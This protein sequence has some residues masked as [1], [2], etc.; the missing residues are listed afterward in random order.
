MAIL[1]HI[2]CPQKQHLSKNINLSFLF[3]NHLKVT[4]VKV[5][6]Y[7]IFKEDFVKIL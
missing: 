5:D 6:H 1:L 3:Q 7:T 2:N 4:V